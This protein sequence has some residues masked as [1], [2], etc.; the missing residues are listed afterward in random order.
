MPRMRV[1]VNE[2][3]RLVSS[4]NRPFFVARHLPGSDPQGVHE[5]LLGRSYRRS[6]FCFGLT[7]VALSDT[8]WTLPAVA[9]SPRA[10]P[11]KKSRD[12]RR[13]VGAGSVRM[14]LRVH[15]EVSGDVFILECEG[16]IVFG[17]EGAI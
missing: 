15:T 2:C 9:G 3:K 6:N 5:S 11:L 1:V 4:I 10:R 17:D 14:A 8:I 13:L 7:T 12:R 16:R